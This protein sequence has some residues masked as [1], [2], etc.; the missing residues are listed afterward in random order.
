MNK[1]YLIL[2][3]TVCFLGFASTSLFAVWDLQPGEPI[4]EYSPGDSFTVEIV[5][6]GEGDYIDAHGFDMRFPFA[7]LEYSGVDFSG[8]LLDGWMFKDVSELS[9]GVLRIAGFTISGKITSGIVGVLVKVN[10]KV[11]A[12]AEGEG[13]FI[14]S[15][16]TDDLVGAT[17][18][19][20][21]FLIKSAGFEVSGLIS[22]YNSEKPI[23]NVAVTLGDQQTVTDVQGTF[24]FS[25]IPGGNYVLHSEKEGD[26][27]LSISPFDAS[28]ILQSI[29]GIISL[30]PYQLIA[31]DVSGNGSVSAFDA[32]YILQYTVGLISEFPIGKSWTFIPA[33][34]E[35]SEEN[36]NTAPDS[37]SFEPLNS[38][39]LNQD[40]VGIVLGDVTGNWVRQF[41]GNDFY[42]A[43][44]SVGEQRLINNHK[45]MVPIEISFLDEAYSGQFELTYNN[46]IFKYLSCSYQAEVENTVFVN[47]E[48]Q[49]EVKFAF[50][51]PLSL[52]GKK[53]QM[54]V[55]FIALDEESKFNPEIQLTKMKIDE[56][57]VN[58][59]AVNN[60]EKTE[61]PNNFQ[62][63]QN[64]P[65]PFNPETTI[66]FSIAKTEHVQIL[67]YNQLGQK[68]KTLLN[69]NKTPG[70]YELNWDGRNEFGEKV[71]SGIYLY[72]MLA[73]KYTAIKKMVYIR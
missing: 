53:I 52:S 56:K 6:G 50:A 45:V 2:F 26:L 34:F 70:V 15:D 3:I 35:I 48:N 27:G 22:Y 8:T 73:G 72:K 41:Q 51:S 11:K 54:N 1:K 47:S 20:A 10:F 18:S 64:H 5:L 9:E 33:A 25:E 63:M 66:K 28:Q 31:A 44:I 36:W 59:T 43:E 37:I 19:P 21:V 30:E 62:L 67:I 39:T 65:N 14:L 32:S 24:L 69:E 40:F 71:G 12:G 7:L 23:E 68:V 46:K 60:P 49:G 29:V 13:Q 57:T 42:G 16:F 4:Y 58:L 61:L 55:Y 38:D 17:T